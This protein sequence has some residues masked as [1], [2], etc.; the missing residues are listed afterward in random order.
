MI[1][2]F[3]DR[4]AAG[5]QLAKHLQSYAHRSDVLVLGLPR[6]G[7]PVAF[8]VAQALHAPLDI[9]L[10]RKLGVPGHA[11]LAMGAIASGGV[12]ILNYEIIS[13]L[14]ITDKTLE[15]VAARE[16]RELQRRDRVYRGDRSQPLIRD[17]RVILVDDGIATGATIRAAIAILKSQDPRELIVA[18]PVAPEEVCQMLMAAV[19]RVVCVATPFPFHA[20]A[21]WY[22][23]FRQTSDAEVCDRLAWQAQAIQSS[24]QPS[25]LLGANSL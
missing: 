10:V 19:D 15:A 20:I 21:L 16:L 6:G 13:R 25:T 18:V 17:Q 23:D 2:P 12:R 7:I 11:E 5:R 1:I 9:C 14:G 3:R 8:E 4:T 22:E 24:Q